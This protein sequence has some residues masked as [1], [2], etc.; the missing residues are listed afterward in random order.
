MAISQGATMASSKSAPHLGRVPASQRK[1]AFK[2]GGSATGAAGSAA[3]ADGGAAAAGAA[4]AF[5]STGTA[6]G[7]TAFGLWSH[8]SQTSNVTRVAAVT[9]T[10]T[11][12]LIR[13][14]MA[15][16]AQPH[17]TVREET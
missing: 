6:A 2:G 7:L 9:P 14:P 16:A 15:S 12:P 13:I 17:S 10:A 3:G 4:F 11:G 8:Q 5:S 1:I